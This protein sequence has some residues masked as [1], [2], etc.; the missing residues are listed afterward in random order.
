MLSL[1]ALTAPRTKLVVDGACFALATWVDHPL[2]FAAALLLLLMA[3][4]WL[5]H[6][7]AVGTT[8]CSR[9]DQPPCQKKSDGRQRS[10]FGCGVSR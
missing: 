3:L 4:T 2:T 9:S 10:S 8:I 1:V 5:R 6:Q 7:S